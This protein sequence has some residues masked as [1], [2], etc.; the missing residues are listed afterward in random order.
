MK[1]G[2]V[3]HS[4]TGNTL[5]VSKRVKEELE[6]KGHTVVL[7]Q[8]KPVDEEGSLKGRLELVDKP[9]I[10]GYDAIIFG[11]PVWGFAP[12]GVMREYMLQIPTLQDKKV[13]CFVTQSFSFPCLGGN[14]SIKKLNEICSSKGGI[15]VGDGIV[16]YT[17]KKREPKTL[18]LLNKLNVF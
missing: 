14:G 9:S 1:I 16:N 8:L 2:L 3:V 13:F 4:H 15:I 6:K 11:A 17:K 7:E 10:S 5:N 18:E 12:S